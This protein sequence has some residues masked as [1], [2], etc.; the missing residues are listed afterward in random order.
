MRT[1]T[2]GARTTRLLLP[3]LVLLALAGA[4]GTSTDPGQVITATPDLTVAPGLPDDILDQPGINI[5][6]RPALWDWTLPDCV[7]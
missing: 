4:A 2:S 5:C 3:G 6:A 7:R 1:T